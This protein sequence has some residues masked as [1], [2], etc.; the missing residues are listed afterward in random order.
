MGLFNNI[1]INISDV[2]IE[3]F[4]CV[5]PHAKYF[6]YSFSHSV[7]IVTLRGNV[8]GTPRTIQDRSGILCPQFSSH[9]LL[10]PLQSGFSPITPP[11][12]LSQMKPRLLKCS[13]FHRFK[14]FPKKPRNES[15]NKRQDEC[16]NR[17][18]SLY[19]I[20]S[21]SMALTFTCISWFPKVSP[22]LSLS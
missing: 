15:C 2:N 18:Y 11:K 3:Y 4:L 20:S 10:S 1:N 9:S 8:P 12:Y 7:I 6:G 19:L 16:M 21:T 14:F 13:E 22:E 5:R 17:P